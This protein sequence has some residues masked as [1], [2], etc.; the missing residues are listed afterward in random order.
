M[1][2]LIL[3]TL[4]SVALAAQTVPDPVVVTIEGKDWTQTE[5]VK[6]ISSLPPQVKRGYD[7]DKQ[8]WLD[9]FALMTRLAAIAKQEGLDQKT[10]FKQQLEYNTMAFLAQIML[11]EKGSDNNVTNEA[12]KAWFES[13]KS[14]YK[15]ARALGIRVSW[16]TTAKEGEKGRTDTEAASII[17]DVIKRAQAGESFADLA[18]QYSE[19]AASKNKGGEFPLFKPEDKATNESIKS[20]IFPLKPGEISKAVR[21]PGSLYVFKLVEFVEPSMQELNDEI[22]TQIARARAIKWIETV[23]QET[24]AQIKDPVFFG[25]PEKK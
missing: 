15:R 22:I 7:S 6:L 1:K 17:D 2:P 11:N 21:L 5:F 18:K 13:N 23:R 25:M 9:Q 3:L 20:A 16:G 24:K 14:Q 12:M 19:D 10:P 4:C 8:G